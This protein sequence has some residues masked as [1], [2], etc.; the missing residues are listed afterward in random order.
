MKYINYNWFGTIADH[1]LDISS[2]EYERAGV[3]KPHGKVLAPE[4]VKQDDIIFV[5]TD[6]IFRGIF[7]HL[8][9]PHI[10][11]R[12][13]LI[14]GVSSLDVLRGSDISP[15]LLNPFLKK[16][17]CTNAP[18][19]SASKP[20]EIYIEHGEVSS[21]IIRKKVVPL[22]IGFEEEERAGGNQQEI[23]H[24]R[25]NHMAFQ[26]KKNKILLPYHTASTNKKRG[27]LINF[28]SSLD[29]VDT[30]PEKLPFGEY[31]NLLNQ[32][33]GVICLE[34]AGHDLH[35][36]YE[37]LLV[38]SIPLFCSDTIEALFLHW[39]IP[40]ARVRSWT[41]TNWDG[42]KVVFNTPHDFRNVDSFLK[43]EHYADII[44]Q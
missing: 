32:Y 28:L 3:S 13:T 18:I 17:Y 24:W 12:F 10:R 31:L 41:E 7:Q 8:F 26:D 43:V 22:P 4:N 19:I 35:R 40:S 39:Q 44:T 2:D 14:S 16:W 6:F 37:T 1:C 42:A 27:E 38:G 33:K 29:F 5:K 36:L 9:L 34:G 11:E 15:I 25:K 20:S 23:H 21:E 30:Q